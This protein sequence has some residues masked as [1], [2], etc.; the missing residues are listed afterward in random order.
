[1][2][3]SEKH[4]LRTRSACTRSSRHSSKSAASAAALEARAKAEA[5]LTRATYAQKEIEVKVKQAQVQA[6]LKVEEARLEATLNALQQEREA[7]A[8]AAE[9]S[10]FEAAAD[11]RGTDQLSDNQDP[12][13]SHNSL[14]RT[15]EYVEDQQKYKEG[16]MSEFA[17][18]TEQKPVASNLVDVQQPQPIEQD[19]SFQSL[20]ARQ[21]AI[22]IVANAATPLI[23]TTQAGAIKKEGAN[24][25]LFKSAVPDALPPRHNASLTS[26][27]H[28]HCNEHYNAR[29]EVFELAKFL[30]R[31]DLLT[32]GLSRFNDKPENYWAW[33]S[34]F[35]NAIEGLDLKPSEELDLLVQ[36]LGPESTEHARR[37][38]SVHISY[39]DVGLSMVWKRLEDCYGSA[40]A[41]EAA[42]FNKLECFP[43]LS[44]K[45]HQ[46]LRELGDLLL[47]LK[48]AKAEGY[49]PG[50]TF[51]D[52][53][54]GISSILEKLPFNLQEKWM[55]QGTRYKQEYGVSFPP[56]SFFCDFICGEARMRNDH[57][58]KLTT[59]N[60]SLSRFE[61][62]PKAIR[63]PVTVHKTEIDNATQRN[64]FNRTNDNL[65]R[66]C[67]IHKKPHPLRKCRGFREKTLLDRKAFLREN[68]ICFKCCS[69]TTHQAKDCKAVIQ[70]SECNSDKH[71]AALHNG[72]APWLEKK[73]TEPSADYGGEQEEFLSP[74]ATSSCTKVCGDPN[75][76][77][78][79]SKIC[80]VNVYPEGEPH[81]KRKVYAVIDD[82]S[83]RSLARSAFF[84]MFKVEDN[85][86]PYMLRTCAGIAKTEGRRADG[87]IVESFDGKTSLALPSLIECN[88]IPN[89]RSEIP[90]PE[91]AQY[92]S[93]LRS[94]A[95]K[96]PSLDPKA[97]ILL[98][99]GRDLIQVHKV[100]EQCNGP[101]HAPFAQRLALGWVIVG[102]ICLNGAHKPATV[103][104]FKTHILANGRPSYM[105][106]CP[107]SMFVKDYFS[108]HNEP[109]TSLNP[110]QKTLSVSEECSIGE[111]VFRC[112]KNDEKTAPSMDDL[113][114]LK[115]M[116]DQFHQDESNSWVA[117]LPFRSPR[118]RLP[119]NKVQANNRLMLL[120]R[121]LRKHPEVK[122]HFVDFMGKIFENGHAELAPQLQE[123]EECW[124]LPMF[125]V[126]H[127]KK[128]GQIRVVFDS[129]AQHQGV[130][131]NDVLLTGP[132]ANNSLLGVLLRFRKERVAVM[133]DI[134][135]MF[136]SFVVAKEH[137]NFLRFLW[138]AN[139]DLNSEV[140]EYRMR[141]H[142]FGNSPS[143]AVAIY[144]LRRA[145]LTGEQDYGFEAR[146]FVERNFYVDDG[147]TSFPTEEEAIKLL[148]DTQEMLA[149]S[150]LHLHKIASNKVEVM[151]AFPSE[152]LA[153]ELKNLDLNTGLPSVQRSLGV[154]WDMS[155]DVFIFQ[156]ADQMRPYTR[157]GV[158]STIN[159]LFNPFG[160]AAPVV[161]QGRLLLRTLTTES[162]DWDAPLSSEKF[163]E[164]KIWRDSLKK[165]ELVK[166]PRTYATISLHQAQ[167]REMCVFCD[168]STNAIA[169]VAYSKITSI[170]GN[171]E[172]GF[173]FGKVKLAPRPEISVP[174]L[175]LCA[176]VLAVEIAE[177]IADEIDIKLDV[178]TFYS[179][180][181]VVLGYICNRSRKFHVY[182]HNRVQRIQRS[183]HPEQ[184]KYVQTD[185]NPADQATRSV[186]AADLSHSMWLT[187]PR[188]L[189]NTTQETSHTGPFA[190]IHP[191]L[192]IEVRSQVISC[193]TH[194]SRRELDPKRF[195]RFSSWHTLVRA[196]ARL[197]HIAHS[198]QKDNDKSTC[199]G[200]HI[201][202]KPC[203]VEDLERA[204]SILIHSVQAECYS[205]ELKC[206]KGGR[207]IPKQSPLCN[208]TP[209]V[210]ELGLLRVGGRLSQASLDRD[211][212]CPIILP[213]QC[214]ITSL[215]IQHYHK[216]VEHQG[217]AFTEG[218][219]R[220][221]G[222]WIIGGKRR[223][224]SVIFQCVKCRRL[225]GKFLTQRMSDLPPE[226]L[227]IDPPFSFVGV[228]IFGP[229]M[230]TSRRTRG[231]QANSKR[232]AVLFTCMST[233][234]IHIEVIE[235]MDSSSFINALRR[236]FA[237]RG[238]A[239]QL[240]SDC[241]TNFV[242]A[243]KELKMEAIT[244][245]RKVQEYL[246]NKS[247]IWIFNPP[248]SSHMG[249]SWERMIGVS[250][251]ILESMLQ[252]IAPSKLSHEVLITFMAEVT[253][254]VNNRPL[255][256]VSTDPDAP[257]ILTP[258]TLL[259][260]KSSAVLP[261]PG[262]FGEK[263]L[264]VRQWRQVQSLANT[265]WNRWRKEYLATLQNRRKWQNESSNLQVGD[266]VLL[267]DSHAKR[268]DWPMGI[269]ME[270]FPGRDGRVRKVEV[271]V[272]KDGV[273]KTFLRPISNV[274]L[275]L[276]PKTE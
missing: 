257:L 183:T 61:K 162:C 78:S 71:I 245:D 154:S 88:L 39:P 196:I 6:Q 241:G 242:G 268:N 126:Y 232:W 274:V 206:L 111:S 17:E 156:V 250:R 96:I 224:S 258:A 85:T 184:W 191:D 165:L 51:L 13:S 116:E 28:S 217:R 5:A 99:L 69:S 233:R 197:V 42:L 207:G 83:N 119:N 103:D 52:T 25:S 30:A 166:I 155:E 115:I 87:F 159:S 107:N 81:N 203:S 80:L 93:H 46:R 62:Y 153:K 246:S 243:C 276:S 74:V 41:M 33:K 192:D 44:N 231:G 167:R 225:R 168:A 63:A 272:V 264:F 113:A 38:R 149:Q 79:C 204:K 7:E 214:H 75:S 223:I 90:T 236:F 205:E 104:V 198:F 106:P 137:R 58:F 222:F 271:K 248:H 21:S 60:V 91:A 72:P 32:G 175:E 180:S 64:E 129:S 227:S 47:E 270:T 55:L 160:F 65:N 133:A 45:D 157:R 171:V 256:P 70:C 212:V 26:P 275:L 173:I 110:K 68:S 56:F 208:L 77:K 218:A 100:E 142:V 185:Q 216:Q 170:S 179:D 120:T 249:G 181:K 163:K 18:T 176:A 130:S 2:S 152:D 177:I 148:K 24:T 22:K 178:V 10:V 145:A 201:C 219:L 269:V 235:S 139:S 238:P 59:Q 102:D 1:M 94:V 16:Y 66:Q 255:V 221:A 209:Y 48:I 86:A 138:Y 73:D 14:Q 141:V 182:V 262:E 57:S 54:R 147:L 27:P 109:K 98:L 23:P 12:H 228:D 36:W 174:R 19:N 84:E 230:V 151:K 229:W 263:D 265:F 210:D 135:Q 169:A 252:G 128:P 118:Q 4:S 127:P 9:A 259:T 186:P 261:P 122:E 50:L 244:D 49:L 213:G 254:I 3:S 234:A 140:R 211:E 82:Q 240:R 15:K 124:Y 108:L 188:F 20:P 260:Q 237:V 247:C 172:V 92:H 158:L 34:S 136:H 53:S 200:W 89:N 31:R 76:R 194:T 215:L 40:E 190:M 161:I 273:S 132:N 123:N 11:I 143:P 226:R 114:F 202:D 125:G 189:F 97:K 266:V 144:G 121:K 187:G 199:R 253:A 101:L 220:E 251:R 112:T 239:K 146:H 8:A 195:E 193:A 29:S 105:S 150:N 37:I 67:P 134:Q 35:C 131:L 164:W 43:K 267:K 117:P 95:S